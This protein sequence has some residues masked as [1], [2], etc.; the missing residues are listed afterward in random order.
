MSDGDDGAVAAVRRGRGLVCWV[1]VGVVLG[2]SNLPSRDGCLGLVDEQ[3]LL[4]GSCVYGLV[5]NGGYAD[6]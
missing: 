2:S 4:P 3:K 5:G 6:T 1:S